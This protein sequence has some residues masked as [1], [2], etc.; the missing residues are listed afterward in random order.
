MIQLQ[1]YVSFRSAFQFTLFQMRS[2]QIDMQKI[3]DELSTVMQL[4][5]DY[6]AMETWFGELSHQRHREEIIQYK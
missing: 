3:R 6:S 1:K 4:K 5:Q 2:E